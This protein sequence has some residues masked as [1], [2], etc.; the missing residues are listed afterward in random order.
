MAVAALG[1]KAPVA[2]LRGRVNL[3]VPS[4][5]SSGVLL[6]LR[7]RG[8]LGGDHIVRVMVTVP[9]TLTPR[10]RELMVEMQEIVV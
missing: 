8:I 7:G 6:K 9:A 10:Q 1:G 3:A 2:T 4:G 5:T